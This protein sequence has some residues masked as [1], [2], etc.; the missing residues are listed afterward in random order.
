M[1]SRSSLFVLILGFGSLIVLIAVM[2]FGA[3]RRADAIYRDMQAAQDSYSETEALRRDV[4]RDL[5]LAD[6]LLRDYLLDPSP[7]SA[8]LHRQELLTIRDS[9]QQRLDEL[10]KHLPENDSPEVA[11]LQ[12]EVEAYWD[13]MD[14]IFEWTPKEKANRSWV[15]L[16]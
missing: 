10:S 4:S 14:P 15:F 5:Y 1:E 8:P 12:S 13:S 6:I 7:Q 3:I 2:G 11:R 9:L 16:A